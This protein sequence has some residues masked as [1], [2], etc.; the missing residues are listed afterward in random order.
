MRDLDFSPTHGS[1]APGIAVMQA[2]SIFAN[3]EGPRFSTFGGILN[4]RRTDG[5]ADL[6]RSDAA[7]SHAT[8]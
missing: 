5:G 2:R 1:V 4:V 6:E 7:Y 8:A 3:T